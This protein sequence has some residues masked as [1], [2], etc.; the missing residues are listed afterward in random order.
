[1]ASFII[2]THKEK[3]MRTT[4]KTPEQFTNKDVDQ[5]AHLA[6]IGFGQGDSV[7]M[8]EDSISHI[9]TADMVQLVHDGGGLMAFSMIRGC[10]W[11]ASA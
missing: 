11:R 1:M 6:G 4:T 5:L 8:R 9:Q 7:Q 2:V 10:L 3:R